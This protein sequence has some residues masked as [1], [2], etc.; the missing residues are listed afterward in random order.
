MKKT[1]KN[2]TAFILSLAVLAGNAVNILPDSNALTARAADISA[3]EVLGKDESYFDAETGT[4]H[5]K[6]YVRNSSAGDGIILPYGVS[7]EEV[8]NI[9]AEKGTVL[10]ENCHCLF[11]G[12]ANILSVDLK[13]ADASDV[14]D[15]SGMFSFNTAP[16]Y[17]DAKAY[18]KPWYDFWGAGEPWLER[19]VKIDVAGLDTSKVTNMSGMFSDVYI[20][21]LDLSSFNTSNVTDM[22]GM[23]Y[24]CV[25]RNALDLSSFDTGNVTDMQ[26]MFCSSLIDSVDLSRF[27]TGNVTDMENMFWHSNFDALDLSSFDTGKVTDMCGMFCECYRLE[28]LD[29]SIFDTS[30]VTDMSDMF[31]LCN[32]LT[33][34]D[35]SGFDTSNVTNMRS[36]FNSSSVRSLDLSSFDTSNV[37]DMGWMFSDCSLLESIIAGDKLSTGSVT[38]DTHMFFSCKSLR[39]GAGTVYDEKHIGTEYAHVDGGRNNP[40]YFTYARAAKD[41]SYFD[42]ET[43]TL[44]LSGLVRNRGAYNGVILPA[45]VNGEEVEHLVADKG[46]VLPQDCSFFCIGMPNLKSADLKNADSSDVTDMSFM[47]ALSDDSGCNLTS[48][49]VSGFDTYNVTNMKG[50][51]KCFGGTKLD[52]RSFWTSNVK[53]MSQMFEGCRCLSDLVFDFEFSTESVTDFSFMF[54]GCSDLK[55][56]DTQYSFRTISAESMAGM[57]SNS[58]VTS[59]DL[60]GFDTRRVTD[61]SRMFEKCHGLTSLDLSSFNTSSVTDMSGM[62]TYCTYL[63]SLD[64]SSFDTKNV[65]D[66]KN[67]FSYCN[68]LRALDLR[69]FDTG[70]VGNMKEMFLRCMTLKTLDLR[71][72]DTKKVTDMSGTFAYCTSLKTILVS[73]KWSAEAA[74]GKDTFTGSSKLT[75]GAG[76]VYRDNSRSVGYARVDGGK[77]APGYFTS[78]DAKEDESYFDEGTRT[79]HLKGYIRNNPG[80]YTCLV[81]PDGVSTED[82]EHVI[83]EKGTIFPEDCSYMFY[84]L[85]NLQSADLKNA[86]TSN[87]TDMSHMLA[88]NGLSRMYFFELY[89]SVDWYE[90]TGLNEFEQDYYY[91]TVDDRGNDIWL[92]KPWLDSPLREIDLSGWDTSKVRDMTMMFENRWNIS[93]LDIKHFNTSNVTDFYGMFQECSSLESLDLSSFDI[94]NSTSTASMFY[95]CNSLT[96]LDVS[97]FDTSNITNTAAMFCGCSS[98]TSLDLSNFDTSNVTCMDLMFYYCCS[99]KTL[100]LSNFD[101]SNVKNTWLMFADCCELETIIAGRNW[102]DNNVEDS[103]AMFIL[104]P[105]LTGGAGTVYDEDH[106]DI[107]YARIDG[108]E[109]APGYFTAPK[110]APESKDTEDI[111]SIIS[112]P[113]DVMND[114]ASYISDILNDP[115]ISGIADK[116]ADYIERLTSMNVY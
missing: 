54:Y 103:D 76:T 90:F 59:L 33:T 18:D 27:D 71:K 1:C 36:M 78:T 93:N 74:C 81:L 94:S 31:E 53:D 34:L 28:S 101:I 21:P 92:I 106:I 60:S 79:L 75:G 44:H 110:K 77:S 5:L 48:I 87:V 62:F 114:V 30:N 72:F 61:M 37:T 85:R 83:A 35:I 70:N 39:G 50:M 98:L 95:N 8:E 16:K 10:P 84:R 29:L 108:G 97:S 20:G 3:S 49:D 26:G 86:D 56:V 38:S 41:K 11:Y 2:I 91:V 19:V 55:S 100:D 66:M 47:F 32:D 23:F 52:L 58:G 112:I 68:R 25:L 7:K 24:K 14:T 102:S 43:A 63:R 64:I 15:M 105:K 107:E 89:E 17:I 45:G 73:S 40:G 99:L 65:T 51:F 13:N 104:C 69:G 6:G 109:S 80:N 4:L 82:V 42:R 57:F 111:S 88:F 113:E 96:S 22:S 116:A 115:E 12:F 67:M 46:T 9:V